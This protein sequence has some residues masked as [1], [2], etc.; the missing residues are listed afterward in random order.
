MPKRKKRSKPGAIKI[1]VSPVKSDKDRQ[2]LF[3]IFS[4]NPRNL[5]MFLLGV[6]CALRIRDLLSLRVKDVLVGNL[7][8]IRI[9]DRIVVREHKT[10]KIKSFPVHLK[11]RGAL[12]TYLRA[13]RPQDPEEPL[14]L[15]RQHGK[16]EDRREHVGP[17]SREQAW[18]IISA[19]GELAGL[20]YAIGTHSM[21]KTFGYL[22]YKRTKDIALVQKTLNHSSTQHTLRYIGIEQEDIDTAH[23]SIDL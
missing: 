21:R 23:L 22:L 7:D 12:R 20:P 10:G 14:F 18:R 13:R 17:I 4:H 16:K 9:V 11:A 19:A 6:T 5:A 8:K 2:A 15:S 3:E 1:P